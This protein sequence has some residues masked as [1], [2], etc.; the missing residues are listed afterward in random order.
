PE[1]LPGPMTRVPDAFRSSWGAHWAEAKVHAFAFGEG[2]DAAFTEL[3]AMARLL[4]PAKGDV[5]QQLAVG[6]DPHHPGAEV[7][8]GTVGPTDV[9]GPH[10]TA[11]AVGG[12]VGD[13]E[14]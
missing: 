10:R 8:G 1:A 5:A 13:G 14:R 4:D 6:V 12:V 3:P 7:L 9:G 2:V 11:K